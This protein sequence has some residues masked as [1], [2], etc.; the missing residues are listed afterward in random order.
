MKFWVSFFLFLLVFIGCKQKFDNSHL[1]I[2]KYNESSGIYTLDPAFAKDQATIW[3]TSQLFN[4]L[5]QLDNNLNI[6]PAIAKKWTISNDGLRY[7]FYLYDDIYFHTHELFKDSSRKVI[8]SDF[9]YSF[10]RLLDQ[11]L[12]APGRWILSNVASF[13]SINDSI[14]QIELNKSFPA[15]LGLL[16]MPYCS[17]VPKEIVENTD[18]KKQPIGTGPFQFQLWEEGV[19]L[20]FRKNPNYFETDSGRSLP[21]LDGISISFIKDKQA[22]FLQFLQ[23]NLDFISG[24]DASYKDEILTHEGKLKD[25]YIEK[26]NLQS[27]PY[28]NT[29][30]LGFLMDEATSP[31]QNILIRMAINHGFDRIKMMKYLRNSIGSPALEGFIPKGMPGFSQDLRGYSYQ[32]EYARE[33]LIKAGFPN[34]EGLKEII[35]STTSSYLDLCEFIQNQ[36]SGIGI[37]VSIQVNPPAVHRNMVA[38][39]RLSFFR[40]SWIADY[41]DAENYLS[42]FYSPNFSPD[43]PN[44]THFKDIKFD[45]MYEE[46]LSEKNDSIRFILYQ[47]MDQKIIDNAV[48]VPLYYDEVLR[49][50]Q[51]KISS[52]DSNSMNTL[53]LK[54][55]KKSVSN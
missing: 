25:K 2:F 8:A 41:P 42:L 36:L 27:Q 26:I 7:T 29:E 24:I 20:I 49:F 4:G 46:A 34:G 31:I 18:F 43:G 19:K 50:T 53:N 40:G 23:G 15:F 16:T 37:N 39:S 6:Q 51:K 1:T 22:A 13:Y 17:V 55:V 14:F 12:T 48:I 54:R 33:L 45:R 5:V 11:E 35:L 21:Y 10:N 44:Y 32:P 47:K 52:F 28:L 38:N 30:Y 3:A 9:S